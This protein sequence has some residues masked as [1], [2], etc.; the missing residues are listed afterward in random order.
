MQNMEVP[1]V[2]V[3]GEEDFRR[4]ASKENQPLVKVSKKDKEKFCQEV[5]LLIHVVNKYEKWAVLNLFKP[6]ELHPNK[7]IA[8][9]PVDL[10]EPN[11]I[12]LGMYGGYKAALI[13]TQ[14][15]SESR[16]ELEDALKYFPNAELILA[17]GVMYANS[18]D[19]AKFGDVIVSQVIDGVGNIRYASDDSIIVRANSRHFRRVPDRLRRIF[20]MG[21]ETWYGFKC[22]KDSPNG[23]EGRESKVL[24]GS[25][26]SSRALVDNKDVKEKLM[27]NSP[28]ALGGE[29]EGVILGEIQESHCDRELGVV[30]IKGVSDYADGTKEKKWQLTASMAA[31]NY[32]Q[33]KLES[34]EGTLFTEGEYCWIK[35]F[36]ILCDL[37]LVRC[38]FNPVP[39]I[40]GSII[41]I[42]LMYGDL[43]IIS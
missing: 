35:A 9:R 11:W 20:A 43:S 8:E 1:E 33:Y 29:M 36:S 27:K 15:G 3:Y 6:P 40:C 10:F 19:K 23:E 12:V 5:K 18:R 2:P 24:S 34:T 16:R 26:S 13:Q 7:P 30:V 31:A 42:L 41:L 25:I 28:E 14:Q 39:V 4:I 17:I 32:A 21:E 38:A 22:T 37:A